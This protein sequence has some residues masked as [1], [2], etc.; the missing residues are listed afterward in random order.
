MN[1]LIATNSQYM[2]PTCVFVYSLCD[3]HKDSPI[4]LYVAY[5]DLRE[6]DLASIEK[7]LSLFEGKRLI[8]INV[9]SEFSEQLGATDRFSAETYYRILALEH[10][11][12]SVEKI[13]Y[14][15]CDMIVNDD[16]E[17]VYSIAL[18]P[19]CPLVACEDASCYRDNAY[20]I[21]NRYAQIPADS[22]YFNA[23][24]LLLNVEYFRNRNEIRIIKDIFLHEGNS[25]VYHDQDILNHM[26]YDKVQLVPWTL[27]NI[28][29]GAYYI[30]Y[31]ALSRGKIR[32]LSYKEIE[33]NDGLG[34]DVTE[35]LANNSKVIHYLWI[36]KPWKYAENDMPKDIETFGRIWYA[37]KKRLLEALPEMTHYFI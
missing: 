21:S 2:M 26:Y 10:L 20:G 25:Y 22:I 17:E 4:D 24:F 30:D 5:H 34:F 8:R 33:N 31:N 29:P 14:M 6:E 16:L 37:N 11:P 13:L 1:I 18:K 36:L 3:K 9:G 28:A 23:G 19:G 32:Y 27:Y 12:Q 35:Q 7:I 15:D